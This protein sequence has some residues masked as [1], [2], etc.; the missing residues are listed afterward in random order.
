MKSEKVTPE[1]LKKY[2]EDACTEAERL[3]VEQWLNSDTFDEVPTDPLFEEKKSTLKQEIWT[4]LSSQIN[5]FSKRRRQLPLVRLS[6]YA[7]CA[8]ILLIL[9]IELV[10]R[11]EET[12]KLFA[13]SKISDSRI[14]EVCERP[15]Y[16]VADNDLEIVFV[17]ETDTQGVLSRKVNCEKGNTYLAIKVKYKSTHEILVINKR[18][19]QNLPPCLEIQ[20]ANE[21]TG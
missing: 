1:L 13:D 14:V 7:A 17:S 6:K 19:I 9:L 20:I 2:A 15:T 8:A 4:S 18:D 3:L 12:P 10:Q 16:I 5:V 21:I 11:Q